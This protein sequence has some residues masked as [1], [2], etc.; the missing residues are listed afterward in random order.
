MILDLTGQKI[1]FLSVIEKVKCKK[2]SKYECLCDC[3]VVT[4][5]YGFAL[6]NGRVKSCGCMKSKL[7][8]DAHTKHGYSRPNNITKVYRAWVSMK[9]RCNNPNN[10]FYHRYGERGIKVCERWLNNFE[11]FLWDMGEPTDDLSIDRID[12]NGNYEPLNCRWATSME[13]GSNQTRPKHRKS[14]KRR[15]KTEE[16]KLAISESLR[17]YYAF[18]KLNS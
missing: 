3:G 10:A 12:N 4:E 11:N 13:Q 6:L 17:I 15:H 18:K 5:T 8:S 9:Q 2:Y 14:S 1:G 16:E 7:L